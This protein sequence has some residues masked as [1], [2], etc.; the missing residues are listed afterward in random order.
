MDVSRY[1]RVARGREPA[2]L[3]LTHAKIIDVYAQ[4]IIDGEVAVADGRI[5]GVGPAGSYTAGQVHDLHGHYLAP[6]FIDGHVHIESAMVNIPEF[7]HAVVPHGTTTVVA[8]PHE[9]ANVLGMTGFRYMFEAAKYNPLSVHLMASSCVPAGPFE[10]SGATLGATD[11]AVLLQDRWVPG[12]AEMMN[13][14]GVLDGDPDV[15]AKLAAAGPRIIDGHAPGLRGLDLNAYVG[16]GIVSDHECTTV[17]EA[18]EKLQKGMYVMIREASPARN[19][20]DLLP[21]VT[22]KTARRCFFVTDDRNP[23]H[24]LDVGHIDSMVRQAIAWGLDPMLALQLACL[25]AAECFRLYDRGAVAPGRRADLV[26]FED[27]RA[28]RPLQVYR[29]GRLVAEHGTLLPYERPVPLP[30]LPVSMNVRRDSL[31]FTVPASGG[32]MRV[33]QVVPDQIVTEPAVDDPKI[34]NGEAAAD[35]GRD[36]LKIAVIERHTGSGRVGIG[37]VRGFGLKLGALGSTVSH[38]AHNIIVVGADDE[39]MRAAVEVLIEM[40]GG[41]VA[42]A[43]RE[44]A[45]LPL[46]IAGLMSDRPVAEVAE[47]VRRLQ[48]TAHRMGSRLDDPFMTLSFLALSVIPALKITDRGLLD[49]NKYEIVPLFLD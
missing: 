17:D 18:R 33:I 48:Q 32:R 16:V 42:V 37:F 36:L 23:M 38:D 49:V 40:K 13:Y 30:T 9:I 24:L 44:V 29:G 15:L 34:V 21:L 11:L 28:P 41:Q 10:S 4:E 47:S 31:R 39:S 43:G 12:L 45:T 5:A 8:D 6:G 2:D 46:P 20:I 22:Q 7:A 27:L 19:L 14:P 3:V 26:T 25:N 35:V 1:I